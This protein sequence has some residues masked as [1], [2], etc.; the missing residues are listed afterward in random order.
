VE[1][2][3]AKRRGGPKHISERGRKERG[4]LGLVSVCQG[5]DL[6][7]GGGVSWLGGFEEGFPPE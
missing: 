1:S 6:T 2:A 3:A 7:G 5:G 4:S